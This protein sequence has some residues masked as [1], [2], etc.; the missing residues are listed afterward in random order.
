M[1]KTPSESDADGSHHAKEGGEGQAADVLDADAPLANGEDVTDGVD[2][3][4]DGRAPLS[5][6]MKVHFAVFT[7]LYFVQVRTPLGEKHRFQQHY[8][9]H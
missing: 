1:Q 6:Q 7:L 8:K 5:R 4:V 9:V 3:E 2:A